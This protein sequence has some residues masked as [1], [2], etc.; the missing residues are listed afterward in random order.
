MVCIF[1]SRNVIHAKNDPN[2]RVQIRRFDLVT[3][4]IVS[5]I[6]KENKSK[7]GCKANCRRES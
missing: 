1:S 4:L 7:N 6:G 2:L 3:C 5:V